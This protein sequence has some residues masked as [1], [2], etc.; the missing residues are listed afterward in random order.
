MPNQACKP[1]SVPLTSQARQGRQS[2][3]YGGGHPPSPATYPRDTERAAPRVDRATQPPVRSCS[4]WGLPSRVS[5]LARWWSL[6][7]PFHSHPRHYRSRATYFL[8]HSS[9][10][11]P[12]LGVTQHRAL[13]SSDFPRIPSGTRD[14]P[15][16]LG[17]GH[18][19]PRFARTSKRTAG[20]FCEAQLWPYNSRP[21]DHAMQEEHVPTSRH[22][23]W[24]AV[25]AATA[26]SPAVKGC[27]AADIALI[28]VNMHQSSIA[29]PPAYASR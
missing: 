9:V 29:I 10:G 27:L 1:S 21:G 19:L 4:R 20:L 5:H 8:L 13:R 12:R 28:D 26:P 23:H 18:I 14:C 16:W 3:L 22:R 25:I 2:S 17:T 24:I 7:P 15:A 6:T 11:S